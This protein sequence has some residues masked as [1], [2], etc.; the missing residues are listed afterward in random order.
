MLFAL[1]LRPFA[2][3]RMSAANQRRF[4]DEGAGRARVQRDVLGQPDEHC[5]LRACGHARASSAAGS[6]SGP[7]RRL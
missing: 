5:L 7:S 3:T 6:D 2:S 4:A 1:A